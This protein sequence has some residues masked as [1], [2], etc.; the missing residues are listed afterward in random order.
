MPYFDN[1]ATTYPKPECVYV[2]MDSFYRNCG[3]SAGRGQYALSAKASNM[4]DDT[5]RRIQK[6]FRCENKSVV[7]THTA[8]EAINLLL[9]SLICRDMTIYTTPFEHNAVTRLLHLLKGEF[10][11]RV[12][13]LS[14]DIA[15]WRYELDSIEEQFEEEPPDL[16]I[17][18]HASNVC[19]LITPIDEI[20]SRAKKHDCVTVVDMCQTAGLVDTDLSSD[21]YDFA[22]FDGHKTLYGP[23][24]VAGIVGKDFSRIKPLIIGGTGVESANQDMPDLCPEKFE[25][26]THNSLSIAGLNAALK[27]IEQIGI[28]NIREVE[29]RNHKRLLEIL[30]SHENIRVIAPIDCE[31]AVGVVSCVFDGYSSDNIGQVLSSKEIAVRTGLHCSPAAHKV[32]NTFPAGTVRFSIGYFTTE[33]DFDELEKVL[34]FI[35]ENA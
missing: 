14:C 1:A 28:D 31:K 20:V 8:T 4:A 26:G 16:V 27:W 13:S 21:Y 19:G 11:I 29:H 30:N 18:S 15:A 35:E 12:I 2:T 17:M 7:F 6:L 22:V 25:A 24:G 34:T 23:F 32:L 5:R 3:A 9:K 33:K 10:N